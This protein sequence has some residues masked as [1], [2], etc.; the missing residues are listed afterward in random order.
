MQRRC[1]SAIQEIDRTSE[2]ISRQAMKHPVFTIGYSRRPRENFLLLLLRHGVDALVDVRS[3]PYSRFR[4]EFSTGPLA[5]ACAAVGIAYRFLGDALGGRPKNPSCYHDGKL[6]YAR[7]AVEPFFRQ[8]LAELATASADTTLALM[9]AE[10]D[11]VDC[12]RAILVARHL[13]PYGL[14]IRHIGP[15]DTFET[16]GAFE[17]RLVTMTGTTPAPLLDSP[18]EWHRAIDE[19][20]DLRGAEM[21]RGTGERSYSPR[22]MKSGLRKPG[23]P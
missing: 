23:L 2:S 13:K 12:H 6:S 8:G 11:P 9:C 14:D 19:A 22:A 20:Y 18:E 5:A 16:L 1:N 15:D 21:T 3:R 7:V 4:P 10:A 17:Q